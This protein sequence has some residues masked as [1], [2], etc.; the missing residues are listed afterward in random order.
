MDKPS[1]PG[2]DYSDHGVAGN[3]MNTLPQE[4]W[5][6]VVDLVKQCEKNAEDLEAKVTSEEM[7]AELRPLSSQLR[8]GLGELRQLIGEV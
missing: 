1:Y 8:E 7:L 2:V 4:N 5:Q 6:H 3:N